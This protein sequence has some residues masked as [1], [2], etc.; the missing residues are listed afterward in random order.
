MILSPSWSIHSIILPCI[1]SIQLSIC[2]WL[3]SFH[4]W[5]TSSINSDCDEI[6]FFLNFPTIIPQI[7]SIGLRSWEYGGHSRVA[8]LYF[9][10]YSWSN[11]LL[12]FGSLSNCSSQFFP[13]MLLIFFELF[14][15]YFCIKFSIHVLGE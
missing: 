8:I 13:P 7:F 3:I 11:L 9:F 12:C 10:K 5:F 4:S 15:Q 1:E 6:F 2:S 14:F